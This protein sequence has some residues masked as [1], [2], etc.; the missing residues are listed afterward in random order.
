LF[1]N[2]LTIRTGSTVLSSILTTISCCYRPAQMGWS[3][4]RARYRCHRRM[5]WPVLVAA[6]L[7]QTQ[8]QAGGINK[9]VL[10]TILLINPEPA[11]PSIRMP[12]RRIVIAIPMTMRELKGRLTGLFPSST[13]TKPAFMPRIGLRPTH[14]CLRRCRL[15]VVWLLTLSRAKKSTRSCS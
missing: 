3:T 14:G 10:W 9:R 12:Q 11:M 7:T 1:L 13:T 8:A 2:S 5:W 6:I 4:W 15:M